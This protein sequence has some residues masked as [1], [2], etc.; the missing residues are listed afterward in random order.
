MLVIVV[1]VVVV[2][3]FP[4]PL[5]SRCLFPSPLSSSL[6]PSFCLP[7]VSLSCPV[8]VVIVV[9]VIVVVIIVL[10]VAVVVVP[11]GR[12]CPPSYTP[13]FHP[14]SSGSRRWFWVLPWVFVTAVVVVKTYQ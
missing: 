14:A 4:C 11:V 7:I 8:V 1:V 3:S 5:S 6:S 9:V 10:V 2:L 13:R 12:P